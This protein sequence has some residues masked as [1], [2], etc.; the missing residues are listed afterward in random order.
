[1]ATPLFSDGEFSPPVGSELIAARHA[2]Q[3]P[4]T[5]PTSVAQAASQQCDD[6]Y[7]RLRDAQ[8][9]GDP[10]AIGAAHV[11][12]ELAL[13]VTRWSSIAGARTRDEPT[14]RPG[15]ASS[16]ARDDGAAVGMAVAPELSGL[17]SAGDV[18]GGSAPGGRHR[19]RRWPGFLARPRMGGRS[20][21]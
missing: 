11:G 10:R 21:L 9:S 13:A 8:R 1:M 18:A 2:V 3:P 17:M 15:P 5:G 12:L 4:W 20:R 16:T 7:R 6:A 14:G 19:S